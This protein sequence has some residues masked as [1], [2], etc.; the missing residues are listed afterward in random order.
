[1]I[2]TLS[3]SSF[4]HTEWW[5]GF[6]HTFSFGSSL[7]T[8][9]A[10]RLGLS[11]KCTMER[12]PSRS[13]SSS[14]AI[15]RGL[16]AWT[17]GAVG[18]GGEGVRV[19][20]GGVCAYEDGWDGHVKEGHHFTYTRAYAHIPSPG[21]LDMAACV[22]L[23]PLETRACSYAPPFP[24]TLPR[25]P[26]LLTSVVLR[27]HCRAQRADGGVGARRSQEGTWR[28][29]GWTGVRH[30]VGAVRAGGTEKGGRDDAAAFRQGAG[31]HGG[32][33][34]WSGG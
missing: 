7:G 5:V 3:T 20:G 2:C 1:V 13:R 12:A 15:A 21:G 14:S 26:T 27:L 31:E 17:M 11:L 18:G 6:F 24:Y 16:V 9:R 29:H 19:C 33:V 4:V 23:S 34:W 30:H 22:H 32:T 8:F 25:Q 10:W 28:S